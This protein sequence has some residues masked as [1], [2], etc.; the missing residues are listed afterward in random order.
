MIALRGGNECELPHVS[1]VRSLWPS[2]LVCQRLPRSV[3]GSCQHLSLSYLDRAI[4]LSEMTADA[5]RSGQRYV[6][7]D[8]YIANYEVNVKSSPSKRAPSCSRAA[9]ET[10]ENLKSHQGSI[11]QFPK[12]RESERC[13]FSPLLQGGALVP[14]EL[15]KMYQTLVDIYKAKVFLSRSCFN[16]DHSGLAYIPS[17]K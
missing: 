17:S 14:T 13:L 2:N 10:D 12:N 6:A 8:S 5:K 7:V 3:Y 9:K 11:S 4:T 1:V 16:P 15:R